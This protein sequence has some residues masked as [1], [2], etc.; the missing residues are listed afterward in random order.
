M[1]KKKTVLT[2][3]WIAIAVIAVASI[4]SLVVFPR[5][6]AVFLV[7]SGGFLIINLLIS[8][9]FIVRNLKD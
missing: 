7:G 4:I 1:A 2:V 5:W 3:M 9:F 8:M 6:K